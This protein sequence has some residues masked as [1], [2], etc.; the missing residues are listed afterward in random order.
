MG[1]TFNQKLGT[2]FRGGRNLKP[3]RRNGSAPLSD[4]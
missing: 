2:P 3:I 4:L 1:L